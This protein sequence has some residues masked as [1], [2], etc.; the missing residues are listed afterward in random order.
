MINLSSYVMCHEIT[1]Q[2][3]FTV[4]KDTPIVATGDDDDNLY[5]QLNQWISISNT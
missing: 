2:Y 4:D 3:L 1:L 5:K